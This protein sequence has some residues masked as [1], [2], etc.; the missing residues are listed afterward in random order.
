[1][2]LKSFCYSGEIISIVTIFWITGLSGSGKTTLGRELVMTL[3]NKRFPVIY[4]D[5]DELREVFG[6]TAITSSN[7]G[8]AARLALAMQ[9]AHLCRILVKQEIIVVIATISMFKEIHAWNRKNLPG[10]FEVYLKVPIE[11]LRRRDPKDIYKRFDAGEIDN[12]AGLD[13]EIDEPLNPDLV[14][15][16]EKNRSLDSMVGILIN[17]LQEKI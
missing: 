10:Y 13:L 6:A 5:G 9:Y 4:L 8:R 12:V 3:Q 15:E 16:Y 14:F 11:E 2:I 1:M 17:K 7:H